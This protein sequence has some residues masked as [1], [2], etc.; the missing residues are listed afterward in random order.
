MRDRRTVYHRN[1]RVRAKS[2]SELVNEGSAWPT[3][4]EWIAASPRS[5]ALPVGPGH[6]DVALEAL[7]VTALSALGAIALETGGVMVD[8]GWIRV[9]GAG[10]A[11]LART[12]AGWNGLPCDAGDAYL[13]GAMFVADDVLGG[14]Y[15]IDVGALG[16]AKRGHVCY[17]APGTLAWRDTGLAY[18]D[19][20]KHVLLDPD[21]LYVERWDGWERDVRSLPGTHAFLLDPAPWLPGPSFSDRARR[22][23]TMRELRDAQL[24]RS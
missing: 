14:M 22:A 23:V 5:E 1:G 21:D 20:L 8:G 4:Q 11:R 6:G 15:A 3:I 18:G 19:W 9:L 13:P 24:R 17:F 12:I 2:S 16:A 10:S 7:Q